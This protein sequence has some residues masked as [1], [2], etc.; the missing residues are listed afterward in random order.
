[1]NAI[2]RT[3]RFYLE[4]LKCC[5][6]RAMFPESDKP[7]DREQRRLGRDW[8]QTAETMIGSLRFG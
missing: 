6:T 7:F 1:M 2:L 4:L 3:E 5:L 8:P